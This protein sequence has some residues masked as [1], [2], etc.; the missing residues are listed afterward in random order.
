MLS[1]A[2]DEFRRGRM[3][4][5]GKAFPFFMRVLLCFCCLFFLIHSIPLL[6]SNHLYR[7]KL[8]KLWM[9]G[10]ALKRNWNCV[11]N[12][13]WSEAAWNGAWKTVVSVYFFPKL[14]D[15][16]ASDSKTTHSE[17][18]KL[19]FLSEELGTIFNV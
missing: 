3:S 12:L 13:H 15:Q 2:N 5:P 14:D 6:N 8:K 4:H 16:E 7:P 11:F 18:C 9:W 17:K 10:S 1:H 19:F